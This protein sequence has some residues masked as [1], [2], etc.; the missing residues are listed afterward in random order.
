MWVYLNG[1]FLLQE[2]AKISPLDRSV[3]FGDGVY[4]VIGEPI[5]NPVTG[6]EHRVRIDLPHGFEYRIAEMGSGTTTTMGG[7]IQLD[8]NK[9][10][11]RQFAEMH[12]GN[13][14]IIE[15]A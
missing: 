3:T 10:T 12:L 11:Y 13:S 4:E 15:A 6:A 7:A 5:K 9:S 2:E 1:K 8:N 14:G